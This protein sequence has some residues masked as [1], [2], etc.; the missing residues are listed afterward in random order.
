M[1][2]H[3]VMDRDAER[4]LQAK[5]YADKRNHAKDRAINVGDA[6]LLERRRVLC[7]RYLSVSGCCLTHAH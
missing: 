2:F 1:V 5:D 7:I 6:V 3:Q 4:K